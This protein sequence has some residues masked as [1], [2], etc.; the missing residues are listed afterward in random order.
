MKGLEPSALNPGGPLQESLAERIVSLATR[1]RRLQRL[2]RRVSH[3]FECSRRASA[4]LG[5]SVPTPEV[6][7][8]AQTE[9]QTAV[10]ELKKVSKAA[11]VATA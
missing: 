9:K 10:P 2:D 8:A 6:L 1:L 3:S 4:D 5:G 7:R 11:S